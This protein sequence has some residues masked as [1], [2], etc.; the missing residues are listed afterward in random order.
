MANL[1]AT[2][3][4]KGAYEEAESLEQFV[5]E[6]MRRT[7]GASH[8]Q[9]LGV[10]ENLEYTLRSMLVGARVALHGLVAKPEYNGRGG[11]VLSKIGARYKVAL[12]PKGGAISVKRE[13]I[14]VVSS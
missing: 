13:N 3:S 10:E 1:G 12:E 6:N 8:P 7:L 9:T 4:K 2:L 14:R 5:L 11:T